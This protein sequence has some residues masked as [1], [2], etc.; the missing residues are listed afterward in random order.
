MSRQKIVELVLHNALILNVFSGQWHLS[1]LAIDKGIIVG[2]GGYI[3]KKMMDLKGAKVI[4]GLIDAHV[5]IESSMLTPYEFEKLILPLGTTTVIADPHEIA[6]VLG[7]DGLR[8]MIEASEQCLLDIYLSLPSCVPATPFE[9]SGAQLDAKD[10][11]LYAN[12]KHV[13]GLGEVMD[14]NGVL[15]KNKDIMAKIELFKRMGKPIDGHAPGLT[16][17]DLDRYISTGIRT[18]HECETVDELREKIEKG[19]YVMIREGSAARN[20]DV[21]I[22]GVDSGNLNR[23]LFCTDDRH[24]Q[25]IVDEGH[26]DNHVRKAVANG[27]SFENAIQ[28]ATIN[29]ANCYQLKNVGAIAPG[30]QADFLIL[31]SEDSFKVEGVYKKGIL[32]HDAFTHKNALTMD[33]KLTLSMCNSMRMRPFDISELEIRR[34]GSHINV[35]QILEGSLITPLLKLPNTDAVMETLLKLV[36]VE[37][38]HATGNIGKAYVSGLKLEHGGIAMTI[39]HDSHNIIAVGSDD[40]SIYTAIKGVERAG[41]GIVLSRGN[42][43]LDVLPLKVAGLMSEHSAVEVTDKLKCLMT[44]VYSEFQMDA[45]IDPF[46]ML[47]F[48]ALPVIPEVKLTDQGLFDVK[49]NQFIPVFTG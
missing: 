45:K 2:F 1:D 18:D 35:I 40:V 34:E 41:G 5:H 32:V 11:A 27:L 38:H 42:D 9:H 48:L 39:A 15:V 22:K 20:F 44:L 30:Y 17:V 33:N 14:F 3:G 7:M 23:I 12:H 8:Y 49:K 10:L 16:G 13:V 21:L 46:L 24:P 36:V 31:K 19:M 28:I 37:R 26:I 4:P 43:V 47:A 25:D 29:A 6:N